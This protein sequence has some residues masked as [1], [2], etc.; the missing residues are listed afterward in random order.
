M[1]KYRN[2][3]YGQKSKEIKKDGGKVGY[4][5]GQNKE[6][7]VDEKIVR[8]IDL[9]NELSQ[10]TEDLKENDKYDELLKATKILLK[11]LL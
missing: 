4:L 5:A 6:L 9:S 2:L 1:G 10:L 7:T 8:I 3:S 11:S